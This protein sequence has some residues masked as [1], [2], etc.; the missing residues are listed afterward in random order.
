L[1]SQ[2]KDPIAKLSLIDTLNSDLKTAMLSK[3]VLS[4]DTIR[5]LLADIQKYSIDNR[6][7][8]SDE[9]IATLINKN[10]KQRRDSIEQFRNGGREDLVEIEQK[11]LS[12]IERY[13]PEQHTEDAITAIIQESIHSLSIEGMKDM[14]KLM[15][16][17][18]P[19]LEGKADMAIVSNLVKDLLG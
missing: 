17:I 19:K 7:E 6:T 2:D 12:V 16:D 11:E 15:S 5:M 4:R 14:G 1:P 18:K 9:I 8:A 10:V 3:D 13:L